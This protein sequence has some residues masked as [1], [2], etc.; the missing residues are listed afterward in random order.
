MNKQDNLESK[1]PSAKKMRPGALKLLELTSARFRNSAP[2]PVDF[3]IPGLLPH[4][5]PSILIAPGGGGKGVLL[6]QASISIS[7]GLPFLGLPETKANPQRVMFLSS[8]DSDE[9]LH[10]RYEDIAQ[11]LARHD[12]NAEDMISDHANDLIIAG[13]DFCSPLLLKKRGDIITTDFYRDLI[14]AATHIKPRLIILDTFSTFFVGLNENDQSDTALA[15]IC[16]KKIAQA[17]NATVLMVHHTNK[18]LFKLGDGGK[19]KNGNKRER[20]IADIGDAEFLNSLRGSTALANNCRLVLCLYDD[21]LI[22][23]KANGIEKRRIPLYRDGRFWSARLV[24]T[25]KGNKQVKQ[26]R[27]NADWL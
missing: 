4:K 20:D 9:E 22:I 12:T 16:I 23:A 21:H 26:E 14:E 24:T 5:V 2:K 25:Q 19:D 15:I 13:D 3:V 11:S 10:R 6:T 18:A 1:L 8:E 7:S 17:A 27:R